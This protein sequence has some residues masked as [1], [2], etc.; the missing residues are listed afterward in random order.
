MDANDATTPV[1][2][3]TQIEILGHRL[4][5]SLM[6]ASL[7]DQSEARD[8]K[9]YASRIGFALQRVH[10]LRAAAAA[11]LNVFDAARLDVAL[12]I[13]ESHV[14]RAAWF[15]DTIARRQR[16][17]LSRANRTIEA[18]TASDEAPEAPAE[19]EGA[20]RAA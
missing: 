17:E 11:T 4:R 19:A 3:V 9:R 2:N 1:H 6:T 18:R 5:E 12:I 15:V 13:L 7:A 14:S 20:R 10:D 16:S 8:A